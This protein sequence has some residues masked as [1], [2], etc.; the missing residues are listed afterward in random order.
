MCVFWKHL[1]YVPI[2][3]TRHHETSGA[4]REQQFQ[5][6][7]TR[8][9]LPTCSTT[10]TQ[11][12]SFRI[13]I[14]TGLDRHHRSATIRP[15]FRFTL[16]LYTYLRENPY[17]YTTQLHT[18]FSIYSSSKFWADWKQ[19]QIRVRFDHN[20]WEITTFEE[21][22]RFLKSKSRSFSYHIS[23]CSFFCNLQ[24]YCL[25]PITFWWTH[26]RFFGFLVQRK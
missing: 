22:I 19:F 9:S 8:K 15:S 12:E 25:F 21:D 23:L 1:M 20:D 24:L 26:R 17:S 11:D 18:S 10:R 3:W 14:S 7:C 4:P 6:K 5:S 2:A 16:M 13:C